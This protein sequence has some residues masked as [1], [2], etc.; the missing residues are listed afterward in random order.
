MRLTTSL[1]VARLLLGLGLALHGNDEPAILSI[2]RGNFLEILTLYSLRNVDVRN[3]IKKNAPANLQ[4]TS[5]DIQKQ[6]ISACASET[7]KDIISDIGDKYFALLLDEARD[8]SIKEQMAVVIRYA[9]NRGEVLDRFV[10]V[11]HVKD[12]TAV[13]LK[14][15]IDDF[16]SKHGLSMSKVRGQGYDGDSNMRGELNGLKTLILNEDPYARYVHC[17][18]HQLQLVVVAAVEGNQFVSDFIDYMSFVTNVV[19]ASC[20]RK[21]E[22]RQKQHEVMVKQ[23]E[24]GHVTTS[25]GLNQETSLTRPGDT[26]WGSHYKTIIRLLSM[27]SSV[28]KVLTYIYKDG[29]E[30]KSRGKVV[31]LLDTME[32]YEF[33][34]I[35]HLMKVSIGHNKW[36][37]TV[38][39]T[40]RSEYYWSY[41]FGCIC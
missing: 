38:L 18:A 9:N 36:F 21:D 15:S 33:V 19:S 3:V 2:R 27:W 16:F 13:S 29:S 20:K 32:K 25:R 41:E 11:V 31:G 12:T 5:L 24:T 22:L 37:I 28:T 4:L 34:F 7:T 30:R 26:R 35:A 39:A 17:F 23:L 14:S 6:I 40:K 8:N 10:G 1:D